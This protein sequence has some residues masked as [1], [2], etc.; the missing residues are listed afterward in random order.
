MLSEAV[1]RP[2]TGVCPICDG[3]ILI[4]KNNLF[5]HCICDFVNMKDYLF[6]GQRYTMPYSKTF[7]QWK[8]LNAILA[9]AAVMAEDF[10]DD[11]YT[12][13]WLGLAGGPGC[14]KSHLLE[15]IA[16]DLDGLAMYVTM[17]ELPSI[18]KGSFG[19]GNTEDILG[20]IKRCPI[21]ILDDVG[22][23][24]Q[25]PYMTSLLH[26][27]ID[28]R[29]GQFD[30]YPTVVSTNYYPNDLDTHID[31]RTSSRLND[32]RVNWVNMFSAK[33]YRRQNAR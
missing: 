7:D 27:I 8:E 21:L 19:D 23:N 29:Y 28:F 18:I 1:G 25:T 33:D 2:H 13:K 11:P 9:N 10:A 26:A 31:P 3:F 17:Q 20:D 15:A 6:R 30:C 32:T 16:M 12:G 14:G 5:L 24:Q 22:A 4:R